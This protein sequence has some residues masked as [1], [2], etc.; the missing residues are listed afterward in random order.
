MELVVRK[1][2]LVLQFLI[3]QDMIIR[4]LLKKIFFYNI[5]KAICFARWGFRAI[6]FQYPQYKAHFLC[7]ILCVRLAL[8]GV[9]S[10]NR[11]ALVYTWYKR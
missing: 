1:L 6:L 11:K 9:R 4:F 8:E 10:Y 3:I 7:V 2:N 5:F